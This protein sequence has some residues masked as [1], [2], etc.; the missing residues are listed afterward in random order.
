MTDMHRPPL[1]TPALVREAFVDGTH[2][3]VAGGCGQPDAVL[4]VVAAANLTSRVR[5]FDCSVPTMTALNPDA[6][7]SAAVL[8]TG[9]LLPP[10]RAFHAQGRVDFVPAYHSARYRALEQEYAIGIALIMVS[11][12]DAAGLCSVGLHADYAEAMLAKADVVVAEINA[13]MPYIEDALKISLADIDYAVSSDRALLEYGVG[14]ASATDLAIADHIS[15]LVEDGDCLQLGIGAL[16]VSILGKLGG[17]KDLG[18]HTGLLTEAIMPLVETGAV[19]GRRKNI[20]TGKVTTGIVAGSRGFYRWCAGRRDLR[21]RP[22]SYTHNA[23]VLAQLE[24][25]VAINTTLEIDLF[26]QINS[27]TLNGR[28]IGGGG[29]LVDFLRGARASRGGRSII[30]L[31]ATAKGGTLSKIVPL[32]TAAPV[33]GM[34]GDIDYVVTE[35]GG[36]RLSNLSVE[37]RAEALIAIAH[38]DYRAELTAKWQDLMA[39]FC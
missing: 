32:L 31:T 7:S 27:E 22:V 12:P 16:P 1:L 9:F 33:T 15:A 26:G 39:K 6:I 25:L 36:A 37:R 19:S 14:A 29:G 11:A 10:Y 3:F 34:R 30:A 24:R 35:F 21:L 28:Q 18:V 23:G 13:H 8:N 20:D 17:K 4:E 38:P 5:V 2:I